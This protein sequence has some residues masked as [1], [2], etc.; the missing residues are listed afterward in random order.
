MSQ[1]FVVPDSFTWLLN[2][3]LA[4]TVKVKANMAFQKIFD[5]AAVRTYLFITL[6]LLTRLVDLQDR[7]G[8]DKGAPLCF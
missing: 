7:F 2:P 1:P 8:K 3:L 4:I 6:S 5:V